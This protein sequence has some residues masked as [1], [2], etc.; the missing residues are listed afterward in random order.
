LSSSIFGHLEASLRGYLTDMTGRVKSANE[1]TAA[2]LA[3]CELPRMAAAL[4]AVLD[5]HEPD[6][7][8]RCRTCRPRRFGRPPAPCRAYLTAH[9]CLLINEDDDPV[10]GGTHITAADPSHDIGH[11]G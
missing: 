9:L 11:T 3:R 4:R 2:N 7:Q 1:V 10:P 8:G 5:E 6:G